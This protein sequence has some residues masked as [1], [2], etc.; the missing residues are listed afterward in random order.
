MAEAYRSFA[1]YLLF[2]EILVDS[3]GHL[4]RAGEID[5]GG[6]R[7]TVWLRIFD[8]PSVPATEVIDGFNRARKIAAA[9]QSTHIPSGVD[10]I[11]DDDVPALACDYVAAQPLSVIFDRMAGEGFP[12]SMDN[13]LLIL[14]KIALAL[15]AALAV[16][17]DGT[18]VV[19]GFLHP[20]LIFISNDGEG[21]VSGFGIADQLLATVEDAD[22]AE[23]NHPYIAPEVLLTHTPSRQGDVYSMG[24]ILFQL[25]TGSAL[26]GRPERRQQA[27]DDAHLVNDE[28]PIPDDIRELLLRALAGQPGD[29]FSSAADFKTELDKLLYGGAYSP[30]TFNL[31]LFID[32]LFRDEA[33][34]YERE[35]AEEKAVDVSAYLAPAPEPELEPAPDSKPVSAGNRKGMLIGLGAVAAAA[36]LIAVVLKFGLG[37]ST[38]PPPPTPTT[39]EITARRQAQEDKM[40][41]LAQG[42]VQ[43]MM[44]EKEEEIRQELLARQTKIEEL[45]KRLQ[46]SERRARKSQLSG[47]E[48][49]KREE[50]QRQIA[51]EEEA[52]RKR[53]AELEEERQRAE[54]DARQQAGAQQAAT[55]TA[56]AEE[57]ALLATAAATGALTPPPAANELEPT[58]APVVEPTF[59]PGVAAVAV[60]ENSFVDPWEVDSLPVVLKESQ[61]AW[62]RS[63]LYSRRKGVVVVQATVDADGRVEAVKVLRADH[64]GFGIPQSVVEAVRMYHFKPGTKDGVPIKTYVT[65][66]QPY[67]FMTR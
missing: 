43:E 21:I 31:A 7:R 61:V 14:E 36:V 53:E 46:E 52:Q 9:V 26:P 63:A 17:T 66:T 4:Y 30:T 56:V 34:A 24:A 51:A 8:S 49:R 28:T 22:A 47:E 39:E 45:Q 44:A 29:R 11:V 40:R 5:R 37:P 1:S 35:R 55:A 42:L 54:E 65:V 16:E 3:L 10:Y 20:G 41:E 59:T 58:V 25:I 60:K 64:E 27:L 18:R 50:L 2:K 67:Y 33:D 62:S 6:L 19:H 13:A 12:V 38:P 32:R 48:Q 23:A 57:E 15:S